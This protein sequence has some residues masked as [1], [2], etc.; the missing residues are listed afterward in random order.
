MSWHGPH[1]VLQHTP[2]TFNSA[3]RWRRHDR[4]QLRPHLS[5]GVC[6]QEAA[7]ALCICSVLKHDHAIKELIHLDDR[8]AVRPLPLEQLQSRKLIRAKL[9]C[10]CWEWACHHSDDCKHTAR[11]VLSSNFN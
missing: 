2:C 6:L 3:C 9:A 8:A 4:R 11:S 7:K 10:L 5:A 1:D